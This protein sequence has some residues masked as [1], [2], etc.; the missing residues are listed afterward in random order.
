MAYFTEGEARAYLPRLR[1]IVA[2]LQRSAQLGVKAGTNGHATVRTPATADDAPL[3]IDPGQAAADWRKKGSS[4]GTPSGA[5]SISPPS[6]RR[7]GSSCS[8]G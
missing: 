8:V 4:S 5:W 3:G 7:A 6:T 1:R 2:L